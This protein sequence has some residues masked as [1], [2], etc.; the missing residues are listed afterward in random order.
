MKKFLILL[1]T[2]SIS[3]LSFSQEW[4]TDFAS[5]KLKAKAE[6]KNILLVFMGSDWCAPCIKL[7][8]E[9][10]QTE[11]F[12]SYALEKLILLKA[13]FPR[14]NKHKLSDA[15]TAHN[16]KLAEAYNDKGHFPMVI[17]L[18][19]EGNVLKRT[20]FSNKKP[21]EFIEYLDSY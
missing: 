12:Q 7:E 18:D 8:K 4:L 20:G 21:E 17:L 13:D 11:T 5:S 9:I 15:Q 10:W 2:W 19:Y 1:F 16:A 14:R 3:N 6:D